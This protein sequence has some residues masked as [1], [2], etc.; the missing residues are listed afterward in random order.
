MTRSLN[1]SKEQSDEDDVFEMTEDDR[2]SNETVELEVII[3]LPHGS[4]P[5][6]GLVLRATPMDPR[7]V[8]A[9]ADTLD[10]GQHRRFGPLNG[11]KPMDPIRDS[12]VDSDL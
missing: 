6:P 3:R 7:V 4:D 8:S 12:I 1:M 2:F 5:A 9:D 10:A 11:A